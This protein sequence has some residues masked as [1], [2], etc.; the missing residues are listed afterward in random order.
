MSTQAAISG[1]ATKNNGGVVKKGGKVDTSGPITKV[2]TL[3]DDA[4]ITSYGAKVALSSGST[5]SSGNLGTYNS[6]TNFAYNMVAG[7]YIMKKSH[8]YT[9]GSSDSTLNTGAS[10][11]GHVPAAIESTRV[12]GSGVDQSFDIYTGS[13]TKGDS[14]GRKAE[15]KQS[16]GSLSDD[17]FNP[18]DAVP[19][20]LA[21][22]TGALEPVQDEYK[23]RT[24]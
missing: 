19:G 15:F 4:V 2:R 18:S 14:A 20:E 12:Y 7:R 1:N 8:S 23:P 13:F 11:F 17:A 3:M 24:G 22:K 16:G 5:G 9:N 21:Y 10:D 6:M